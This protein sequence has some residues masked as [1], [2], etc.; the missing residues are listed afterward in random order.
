MIE[1]NEKE[2][3]NNGNRKENPYNDFIKYSAAD[4][5]KSFFPIKNNKKMTIFETN[6]IL[7]IKTTIFKGTRESWNHYI[8]DKIDL[9][10]RKK[11][12]IIEN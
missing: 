7:R 4:K 3:M 6:E 9:N 12:T 5:R 10:I 2:E 8:K 11:V 1:L